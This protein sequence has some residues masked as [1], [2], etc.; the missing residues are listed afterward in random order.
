[1]RNKYLLIILIALIS[2]LS[3]SSETKNSSVTAFA[4]GA[5][6]SWITQM[7]ASGKKFYTADGTQMECMAL[8]KSL[9]MNSIRLRVWVNPTDS[10]CNAADL[11]V[12]AKRANDLG[13]RIMVDFH[14]SD[15]WA[16]PGKQTK[17][18]AWTSLDLA[19]LK[20]AVSSHTRDML[21]LLKNNNITPEWVQVGN[22][23]G[24]GMLWETGKASVS[25]ANYA[26]LNNAGYDAV[27][28][29]F[30]TAKVIVHLHNGYDNAMFRWIFDG[31]KTNGGKYD[32]IG[33]SLYPSWYKTANDWQNANKDCLA[34]MNDMVARYNKEVMVVECGM[35]WDNAATAKL[36]LTDII[37][38]TK[39]VTGGK[40]TGVFYWEPQ[41]YGNW[42][43]YSL[44]AFDNSGKPT[45]A[46]DAFKNST[47]ISETKEQKISYKIDSDKN[48]IIFNKPI[49]KIEIICLNGKTTKSILNRNIV[50]ASELSSEVNIL[51]ITEPDNQVSIFKILL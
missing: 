43:G 27:K 20:L 23:T 16:D 50:S 40:G 10:W 6:V 18:V 48:T 45:I 2:I 15:S 22:E 4:A 13:L 31:L 21:N 11:L 17:P 46:M 41:C 35:S 7:E 37:A 44:G 32:V 26:A 25:M 1:M 34:N 29:V 36:F 39:L 3:V 19:G 38:K 8:L 9:G 12:K 49:S 5:D 47:N 33:M 30:P 14:Y 24:N 51:K 42:Q 28:E